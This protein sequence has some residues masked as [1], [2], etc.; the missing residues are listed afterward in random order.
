MSYDL[1]FWRYSSRDRRDP[2][3]VYAQLMDGQVPND[4]AP[5]PIADILST[6]IDRHPGAVRQPNGPDREWIV[7]SADDRG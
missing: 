1:V 3:E 5:L 4:L 6:I 7:W 2:R